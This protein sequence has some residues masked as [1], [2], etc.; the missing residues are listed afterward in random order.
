[1]S[2]ACP[3]AQPKRARSARV[4]A[5]ARPT[6]RS[7]AFSRARGS[8][9]SRTRGSRP[10]RRRASSMSRRS[11][12][13]AARPT[14]LIAEILPAI[15][16]AFPWPKSMRWGAASAEPDALRWVRPLR[17]I[18][19]TFAHPARRREIVPFEIDGITAGD[20]TY[21]HRFMAPGPIKVRRFDDYVDALQRQGRARRR[22]AQ[23]DHPDRRQQPRVRPGA[24]T[25][26]GRGT[27]G[28]GRRPGRMAGR[29]DG[30]I[31][32]G[33]PR[34]SARSRSAPPS[35]PTRNAS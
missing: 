18:L 32:G 1:M 9:G 2:S 30:R 24:R 6:P 16:R 34:N 14:T 4:R 13:R 23:G 8:R 22:A 20:V 12:S 33:V 10:T 29:A 25:R 27:A 21:G 7:R 11:R 31:R 28:G 26:R 35:A 5:S 3:A 17:A 19:C 15:I